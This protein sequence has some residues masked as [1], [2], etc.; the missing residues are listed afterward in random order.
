MSVLVSRADGTPQAQQPSTFK[1]FVEVGRVVLVNEGPSA[2]NLAVIAEII[3]HNR[4]RPPSNYM[5]LQL[6]D[7]MI[8]SG[9]DRRSNHFRSPPILPLPPSYPYP[10]HTCEATTR[11]R[12][13]RDQEGR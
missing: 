12:I 3:D 2:G 1:R 9:A 5:L 6:S 4:V 13:R 7:L 8:P 11:R 10:L